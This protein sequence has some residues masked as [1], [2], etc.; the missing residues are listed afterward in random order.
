MADVCGDA[1]NVEYLREE[2]ASLRR[3]TV[4]LELSM[5]EVRKAY[6]EATARM[7]EIDDQLATFTNKVDD[8]KF[9]LE[10]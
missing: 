1:K 10:P 6:D 8:I 7:K 9:N 5:A 3:R 2:L 4:E